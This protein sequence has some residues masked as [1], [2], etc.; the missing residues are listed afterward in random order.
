[1]IQEAAN[2]AE[3]TIAW[4]TTG[5]TIRR[6]TQRTFHRVRGKVTCCHGAPL[7]LFSV[8]RHR[9]PAASIQAEPKS[10]LGAVFVYRILPLVRLT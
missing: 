1:M 6:S 8:F 4:R 3:S 9:K 10:D 7:M 2:G 5:D